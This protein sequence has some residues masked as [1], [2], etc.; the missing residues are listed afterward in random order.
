MNQQQQNQE[1]IEQ[2]IEFR[3]RNKWTLRQAARVIG[4]DHTYLYRIEKGERVPSAG[5]VK[6]IA[7]VVYVKSVVEV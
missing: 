5:V 6:N 1:I 2:W 7:Y 4:V 3:Q